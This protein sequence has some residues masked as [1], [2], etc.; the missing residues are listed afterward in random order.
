[1]N[2]LFIY[3]LLS[4]AGLGFFATTAQASDEDMFLDQIK[5]SEE[6]S[7]GQGRSA[8]WILP[9]VATQYQ[10]ASP[11]P[12]MQA[13]LQAQNEARFLDALILLEHEKKQ[14]IADSDAGAEL[15]LLHAS[16][17]IQGHQSRQAIAVLAPLLNDARYA[18]DAYALTAMLYVQQGNIQQAWDAAQHAQ[19]S[20][21]ELLP[22]LA[23][24]YTLQSMGRLAEA[25]AELHDFNRA[26]TPPSAIALAREAELALTLGQTEAA[27]TLMLQA[28]QLDATHPYVTAVGGL[29]FLIDGKTARAQTAFTVALQRDPQDAKALFGLGLTEIK[30]G[31]LHAGLKDLQAA[32]ASDPNNALILTYLGRVQQQL[33][34]SEAAQQSWRSAQLADPK[35]PV[36]YLYQA[37]AELQANQPLAA[38]ESL[39]EA[40]A[41]TSNRA[42]YRGDNL[43]KED[44][45]ILQANLAEVQRQ[46]GMESLAFATLSDGVSEKNSANLRNQADVLQGQRFGESARRSLLLQSMFNERPGNLPSELD[47]Y[48]DSAGQ[49]GAITPQHGAISQLGA[50]QL[51]FNNYDELFDTRT[52]VAVDAN[53]ASQSTHGE[54]VR[55]GVG[56]DTLGVSLAQRTYETAGYGL[57][58]NLDNRLGQATLQW[59]PTQSTQAFASYQTF[60]SQHG[61]VTCPADPFLCAI[62]HRYEDTSSVT[63]VGLHQNFDDGSEVRAL[64]SRQQTMQIDNWEWASDFLSP[65]NPFYSP[66]TVGSTYGI[67]HNSSESSSAELQYRRSG[68]DY[69]A[70]WGVSSSRSALDEQQYA[71]PTL[72]QIAQQIYA[73]WQFALAPAWQVETGLA[74]GKRDTLW[75]TSTNADV[76]TYLQRW[77]PKLGVVYT[78]DD[79]THLRLAAW[80]GLDD[81]TVGN[82]SL[83]SASLAGF[84]LNR[85]G[86]NNKLARSVA[87][88]ADTQLSRAWL[89]EA[90]TQR[91]WT[92]TI[93]Y[94]NVQQ[95]SPTR[96]DDARLALHWQ[97]GAVLSTL[98][99]DDEYVW[100][101]PTVMSAISIQ[102]QHLRATQL[103]LRWQASAQW[104]TSVTFSHNVLNATQQMNDINYL[105]SILINVPQHFDLI[106]ADLN[107]QLNRTLSAQFGVRNAT[108]RTIL[109]TE[110][111]PLIPRFSASRLVYVQLKL[112]W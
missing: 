65:L 111:D 31:D 109:Y 57:Y 28:Q 83:S 98:S 70:Q 24:S 27:D 19:D 79:A 99:Y 25:R 104:A 101:D 56:S 44:T 100:N 43:L 50:Q 17:L 82:A 85:T 23:R 13:A 5:Q 108:N 102:Q 112:A 22:H 3:C 54:Q 87:M 16:F 90:Q 9:L 71:S 11:N 110:I 77:L 10:P 37:R 49:T 66:P 21:G 105:P 7:V 107:W 33:G 89:L 18:A 4:I 60:N 32:N 78:P 20:V 51:S 47:I 68:A 34:L 15:N 41:R 84:V 62:N 53:S 35:D 96:M 63:R 58:N 95:M 74:W 92:D 45:Q 2:R 48:G 64:L 80:K 39:R 72:S 106:D 97:P 30:Q 1:M 61:E 88:G 76:S 42:V 8:I 93:F 14:V 75:L 86:E 46:L 59:R 38:R 73:S 94:A 36:P 91:R 69:A 12:Q 81:A 103:N 40:Q 6:Q 29:V 55:A 52:T 67:Y 26:H